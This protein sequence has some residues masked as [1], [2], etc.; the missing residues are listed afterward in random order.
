MI[1]EKIEIE[2]FM[3]YSKPVELTF[4]EGINV[5]IGDNGFGKSKLYDA[6]YWV[7]YDQVFS[8]EQKRFQFTKE[9]KSGI[10]S[11]MAKHEAKNGDK[12]IALVRVTFNNV[13]KG[14]LYI[15]ENKYSITKHE[16]RFIENNDSEPTLLKKEPYLKAKLIT[17]EQEKLKIKN[18][19]LPPQVKD[20]LWFQGEQVESIID[21]NDHDTLRKAINVLSNILRYDTI[22]EIAQAASKAANNEYDREVKKLSKDTDKSEQLSKD[23]KALESQIKYDLEEEK[24]IRDNLTKADERCSQLL[25]QLQDAERVKE[26]HIKKQVLISFLNELSNTQKEDNITFHRKMF[27]NKWVLKGTTHLQQEFAAQFEDYQFNKLKIEAEQKA[28]QNIENELVKKLQF[29]LPKDVPEPIYVLRMLEIEKCL[30]CDREAK[31]NSEPW[32]KM[33]ELVDRPDLKKSKSA[34]QKSFNFADDLRL[35][36]QNGLTQSNR[37]QHIDSDINEILQKKLRLSKQI[38]DVQKEVY[39]LEQDI[40]RILANTSLTSDIATNIIGE[41]NIQNKYSK[42]FAEKLNRVSQRIEKDKVSLIAIEEKLKELVT[43]TISPALEE[44]K[45]ILNDFEILSMNTKERVFNKLIERLEEESNKHYHDMTSGNKSAK[46]QI[47]LSKRP[48]G[49]YMPEIIDDQGNPLLGSNTSNLIL[50]KLAAIMAIISAKTSSDMTN[51]YTLIT[52][53]PTSVFGEDYTIGFCKTISKVYRQSIIMS[54]E[55]YKNQELRNQLLS[56]P[57]IKIGK[58]YMISPSI[59]ESQR[60]NRNTLTTIVTPLN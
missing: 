44:K 33:K 45:K 14:E 20:Y 1:L 37:I 57:D 22:N 49:N 24:Q 16:N 50:V 31:E 34:E 7:M 25:S 15:L 35:L 46:G 60:V 39:D 4:T 43:G 41:F 10:V 17:D 8:S 55:F 23:K 2:N 13:E 58:V 47:K 42:E 40:E 18:R 28:Y 12:I 59:T 11:D 52:D 26:L 48:N 36:Y 32:L 53:A 56:S 38:K 27:R 3:C 9:I 29:R 19:I 6:F 21:F 54:K 51:L 5:V 30:V